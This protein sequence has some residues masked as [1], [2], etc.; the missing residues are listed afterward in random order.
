MKISFDELKA[1]FKNVLL[2]LSFTEEKAD[3]CAGIF[4]SNSRDGVY[5]HGLNRFPVFVKHVQSGHIKPDAEPVLVERNGIIETYDGQLGPGIYNASVCMKRAT[6]L[7]KENGIGFV[8]IKNTNHWMRG[9]T[10]GW[11]AADD[12]CVSISFTNAYACMP[13]WG[14]KDARL[15]N[16]PLVI[17][18]PR[19]GGHLVLDMA[20]SQYSYGK[21]Q[22]YEL[23]G[24]QLPYAGGVDEAGELTHDPALI[25]KLQSAL[26]AGLW[27][28]SGLAL[29]LDVLLTAL[30][31]GKSTA[32]IAAA[33]SEYGVSQCFIA[34]NS[35]NLHASLIEEILAYTKSSTPVKE[36]G[37]IQYPGEN[38]LAIRKQNEAEGIP[39]NEEMWNKVKN[40]LQ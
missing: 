18:V 37:S 29:M 16:N 30:S 22:T 40:M 11:Q 5:S 25:Y 39:V 7:A 35:P 33:G 26:P 21:M 1:V 17:G 12:G 6:T 23:E 28:G 10:Y 15:G 24:K 4:A 19:R 3:L 27:K 32:A 31:G 9:G 34:I 2:R 8:V 36:K 13:P 38:T 14:G 20:M